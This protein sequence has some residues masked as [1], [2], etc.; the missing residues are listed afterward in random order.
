MAR[1][2]PLGLFCFSLASL[3]VGI[4][5]NRYFTYRASRIKSSVPEVNQVLRIEKDLER[6]SSGLSGL[7]AMT[8]AHADATFSHY[9][10]HQ[11]NRKSRI[12]SD[13]QVRTAFEDLKHNEKLASQFIY[14]GALLSL[15][16]L[17]GSLILKHRRSCS[18][19][20]SDSSEPLFAD[21]EDITFLGTV[22]QDPRPSYYT[23]NAPGNN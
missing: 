8:R 21:P 7:D 19:E 22:H 6:A 14:G 1:I 13:P 18:Y 3:V 23:F 12:L 17:V 9:F 20:H 5:S 10:T 4:D 2:C 15:S 11:L 16:S